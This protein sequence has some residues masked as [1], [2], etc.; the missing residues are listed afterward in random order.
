MGRVCVSKRAER[1]G[2]REEVDEEGEAQ[3]AYGDPSGKY[4]V[5]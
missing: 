4:L 5:P 3:G 2:W 1:G